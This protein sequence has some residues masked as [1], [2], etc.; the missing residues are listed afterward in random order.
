[1]KD[2]VLYLAGNSEENI[3]DFHKSLRLLYQNYLKNFSCD[4]VVFH[5]KAF[6]QHLPILIKAFPNISFKF[7]EITFELPKYNAYILEKIPEYFPHPTHGNGPIAWGHPGFS[8][9]Y[10]HMCNFFA[11]DIY[12]Q[13]ALADY[14]YYMRLDTDSYILREISY[15][16]FDMMRNRNAIYGF[17]G[18]A[19]QTDNSKVIDG[20]WDCCKQFS[21]MSKYVCNKS[22]ILNISPGK[23][24]YNNFEIGKISWFKKEAYTTFY[25]HIRDSGG[26]YTKRWGDAPI[27]YL[28]INLLLDDSMLVNVTD[29]AYQHG[30]VYNL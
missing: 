8:M 15:N 21:D 25:K 26:I 1:M 7:F 20:L 24:Y 16:V 4:V 14:D 30:A 22:I 28:G 6:I 29:I 13:P 10:R 12:N 9:G 5:E 17:I 19:I 27:R 11:G 23:M 3:K 18:A 2:C